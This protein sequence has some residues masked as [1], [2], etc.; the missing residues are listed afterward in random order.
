MLCAAVDA[1]LLGMDQTLSLPV[2]ANLKKIEYMKGLH[3]E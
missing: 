2:G 3:H 1:E